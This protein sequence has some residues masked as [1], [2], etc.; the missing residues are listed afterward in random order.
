MNDN[1]RI[2]VH[3]SCGAASAVAAK[4]A[5]DAY[6]ST[7]EVQIVNES[8]AKDEHPDNERFL[9]DVEKWIGRKVI[10]L[11]HPKYTTVEECWRGEK[12]IVGSLG[13]ACTRVMKRELMEAYCRPDDIHVV[14]FTFDEPGRIAGIIENNP[15]RDFLWLLHMGR[16]SKTD[17]YHILTAAGIALPEMYLLGFDHNNCIGCCKGGKGYWNRVRRI[18]PEIF[19]ARAKIQREFN[20]GFRSGNTYFFL[21]ELDPNEGTEKEPEIVCNGL[22]CGNYE[23]LVELT[24]KNL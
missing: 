1:G 16:I 12:Y 10:R 6:G 2:I 17:C 14:G 23:R 15:D 3:F 19:S 5:V 8:L 24:V 20:V 4:I 22:F 7:R 21:D 18:F 13:A 9:A 11:S